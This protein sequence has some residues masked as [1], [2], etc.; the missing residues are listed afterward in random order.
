MWKGQD[1]VTLGTDVFITRYFD[2]VRSSRATRSST[3]PWQFL[4]FLPTIV[5]TFWSWFKHMVLK[6]IGVHFLSETNLLKLAEVILNANPRVVI[7]HANSTLRFNR[8]VSSLSDQATTIMNINGFTIIVPFRNSFCLQ[9]DARSR[10]FCTCAHFL[11]S[12]R[13][14]INEH[15]RRTG[16]SLP[17]RRN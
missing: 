15:N 11:R 14:G 17:L 7:V 6:L 9:F 10:K 2:T 3:H 13:S 1:L 16:V 4:N 12:E 5:H 8:H